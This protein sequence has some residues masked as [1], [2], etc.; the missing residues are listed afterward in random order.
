[1]NPNPSINELEVNLRRLPGVISVAFDDRNSVL[2]IQL[3]IGGGVSDP[4]LTDRA[5]RL[6]LQFAE[7]SVAIEVN[8]WQGSRRI[9]KE[10]SGTVSNK[11][12]G[13]HIGDTP[14]PRDAVDEVETVPET[15]SD[16]SE[17]QTNRSGVSDASETSDESKNRRRSDS[18]SIDADA[19]LGGTPSTSPSAERNTV[20]DA[21][22]QTSVWG[23]S[24]EVAEANDFGSRSGPDS[25][26]ETRIEPDTRAFL[27]PETELL[28][29]HS[30]EVFHGATSL[31]ASVT[32]AE[33]DETDFYETD[34]DETDI[35]ETENYE[36]ENYETAQ[37]LEEE[38][39]YG[40]AFEDAQGDDSDEE[41]ETTSEP[42]PVSVIDV[43]QMEKAES[44]ERAP[45]TRLL[46]VLTF[47]DTDELEVHLSY[48][49][50]RGIGRAPAS[51]GVLGAS[52]AAIE[53][54]RT[55]A[56]DIEYEAV[57]ARPME[58]GD[59]RKQYLVAT[60]LNDPANKTLHGLATGA[61][62]IEAAARSTL[63]AL[64]RTIA[65]ALALIPEL[66]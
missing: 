65:P 52:E 27:I 31:D 30:S 50:R 37:T 51:R 29:A 14:D 53:A 17:R 43:T 57:W 41:P 38:S 19:P 8:H 62:P 20:A 6:A 39:G 66:P 1:M 63:H 11:F 60:E 4:T 48:K 36:I 16:T 7:G 26:A 15:A 28:D 21:P 61:S 40:E 13:G 54:L 35:D 22:A 5:T 24:P 46:A 34:I 32:D 25:R 2:H 42:E 23:I 59:G 56:P 9:S 55:W 33:D 45:R 49:G 44:L 64:N 10:Q 12:G 3:H 18:F 47:P 58:N